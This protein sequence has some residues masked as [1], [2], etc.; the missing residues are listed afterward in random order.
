MVA[1]IPCKTFE[2]GSFFPVKHLGLQCTSFHI[3]MQIHVHE[4]LLVIK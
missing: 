4:S 3:H 2:V 1:F